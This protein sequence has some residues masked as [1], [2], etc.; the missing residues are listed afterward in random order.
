MFEE[1][2]QKI[3]PL[4]NSLNLFWLWWGHE[5]STVMGRFSKTRIG[6]E[7]E[8]GRSALLFDL[9]EGDVS[10]LKQ[11]GD[12]Y[13]SLGG[14]NVADHDV[15][16]FADVEAITTDDMQVVI[17]LPKKYCLCK[18]L[19]LPKV[20]KADIRAVLENQIDRLTP[21]KAEQVY[22][23]YRI[24]DN[25]ITQGAR[26][27]DLYILPRNKCAALIDILKKQNIS[28][29]SLLY[30]DDTG[31]GLEINFLSP[32]DYR[33]Q[34]KEPKS[35][36]ARKVGLLAALMIAVYILPLGY[37]YFQKEILTDKIAGI[38][39]KAK[40]SAKVK[41]NYEKL[42]REAQF[43]V[44]KKKEKPLTL[45]LINEVSRV[46]QDDTWL[47]QLT[48]KSD[49]LQIFGYSSSASKV[50]NDLE[51]SNLFKDAHFMA[52]VVYQK[53]FK[54]ERF[55]IAVTLDPDQGK[56]EDKGAGQ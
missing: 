13:Q 44:N 18:R 26:Q 35:N 22:F 14:F 21:Y 38:A 50:L 43:L 4:L 47:D 27:I 16:I 19:T 33:S 41:N 36:V 42:K 55:H 53:K 25:K 1:I 30:E 5:L 23:D 48:L 15:K 49:R 17:R 46:L 2:K 52:A 11:D 54:A 6:H 56:V 12:N 51:K 29:D 39:S 40:V 28:V 7:T 31:S 8:R 9:S 24:I 20:D 10:I 34:N 45:Q 37:Y 3:N 32:L